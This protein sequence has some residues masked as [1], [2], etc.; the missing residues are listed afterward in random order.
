L[1]GVK[2]LQYAVSWFRA[3]RALRI[4]SQE[5]FFAGMENKI[6]FFLVA[7]STDF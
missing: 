1:G 3:A 4:R 7:F 5:N 6:H 2:F